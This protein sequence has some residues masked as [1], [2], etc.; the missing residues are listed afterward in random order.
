MFLAYYVPLCRYV[1][2]YVRSVEAAEELV[3]D[4]FARIWELRQ[5]WKP[6][7]SLKAY[8]YRAA[9][10]R[11]LDY[12][13][14]AKVRTSYLEAESFDIPERMTLEDELHGKDFQSDTIKAIQ[15]L[16]D[17]CRLIYTLHRQ[18]GVTYAEI[19]SL[20]DISVKTVEAQMG[21]ALKILRRRLIHYLF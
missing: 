9:R 15:E 7:S 10:N 21:R 3:Q 17:R 1:L 19:A 11:S 8:L 13:K 5:D 14:A 12:L 4:L 2:H 6:N 18:D 20:L 16:P